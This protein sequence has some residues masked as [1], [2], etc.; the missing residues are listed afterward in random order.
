MKPLKLQMQAFGPYAK[1]EI[2]DF[3]K[4]GNRNMF[5]ISGK[6][7]AGK[8]TIFDGISFAIY[9]KAS[10]DDRAGHDLRSHFADE[11]M[12]TEV[13]LTFQLRD[14]IYF[15]KRSPK[16]E[17]K[18]KNG[19]GY[20]EESAKAELYEETKDGR[21][22]LGSN[23][24]EVDEKIRQ[25]IGLD[26][27]QFKQILMIPQGD[28]K[29]LLTSESKEKELI[30]QKLFH[31][32]IYKRIEEK[33]KEEATAAK[34]LDK[35]LRLEMETYMNGIHWAEPQSADGENE[36]SAQ[37]SP[38][39]V[40]EQ[41]GLLVDVQKKQLDAYVSEL[42]GLTA[43][44]KQLQRDL[45]QAKDIADK[46]KELNQLKAEKKKLD[47]RREMIAS[48]EV[49]LKDARKAAMLEK[50]EQSYVKIGQKVKDLNASIGQM[51]AKHKELLV[52]MDSI[53]QSYEEEMAKSGEREAAAQQVMALQEMRSDILQFEDFRQKVSE[54]KKELDQLLSGYG[55]MEKE[56]EDTER[57]LR[58]AEENISSAQKAAIGHAEKSRELEKMAEAAKLLEEAISLSKE[59]EES[60]RIVFKAEEDLKNKS[61]AYT[62]LHE[63]YKELEHRYMQSHASR[64][65]RMLHEGQPCSVCGSTTHPSPANLHGEAVSEEE[66]EESKKRLENA[67]QQRITA[68]QLH[69]KAKVKRETILESAAKH[70]KK[71]IDSVPE[72]KA[73]Q[74]AVL[75]SGLVEK[76]SILAGEAAVLETAMKQL[77][78][79]EQRKNQL[80]DRHELLKTGMKERKMQMDA[81]REAYIGK[82]TRLAD[83]EKRLPADLRTKVD[84]ERAIQMA[85]DRK[86]QLEKDLHIKR[87][88][89]QNAKQEEARLKSAIETNTASLYTM[90]TELT[91]ER[92]LFKKE[93][94]RQGFASYQLY[95]EAKKTEEQIKLLEG[96]I[97]QFQMEDQRVDSLLSNLA[98]A[99]KGIEYPDLAMIE[100]KIE[101]NEEEVKRKREMINSLEHLIKHHESILANI[102]TTIEKQRDVQ[103]QYETIGHLYEL[104]RGSNPFRITFERFVLAA[105][106][107]DILKEANVRLKRM[108]SGRYQLMRKVDPTRRNVQSGLELTVFDQFTG[109]ERHVKTLSGGESF[110]ASLALALGLAAVVQQNAGGIS[111]ETMFIDEGFGTLDPE[112]LDQAIE[113]LLEI[114][115]SGRLVGIISHVPELKERIDARLE[116]IGRQNGSTTRFVLD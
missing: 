28:F 101:K 65:A 70:E 38:V 51:E 82:Q 20:T 21:L 57:Q 79:M 34:E 102:K 109:M 33:L 24:K 68:E 76:R 11:D 35:R 77:P 103:A 92:E 6:T 78:S 37:G 86:Q 93:M 19:N 29:K 22:L 88:A 3:T 16:Q 98:Y 83:M 25:I 66:I 13:S 58:I 71:L 52:K 46:F 111:L 114:Q 7:G 40:L 43:I 27:T 91:Q 100:Q 31:T 44:E 63:R 115:S 72:Y 95:V 84:Y 62:L 59:A 14:K 105:F 53:N 55:Q 104:S 26:A 113:S 49:Q 112:S 116:V 56:L 99:L 15:I 87:E 73:G 106:L 36:E 97:E 96:Q 110:K 108:T 9:G 75:L 12:L 89:L 64:L 18:K 94:D 74:T 48:F 10:G 54:R 8:T 80:R 2:I 39:Q 32:E 81:K 50:Q 67:D 61:D 60:E 107:D 41:L 47:D 42:D 5:V 85:Q 23:I 45:F 30:L 17:R 69:F 1:N 4:L 90:Q